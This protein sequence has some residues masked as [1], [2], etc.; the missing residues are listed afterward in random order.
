MVELTADEVRKWLKNR[1][2][3][4][5]L[6]TL[7]E[8]ETGYV[9]KAADAFREKRGKSFKREMSKKKKT[10]WRGE[11]KIDQRSKSIKFDD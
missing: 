3:T 6:Q 7:F 4:R 1:N 8:E 2:Y 5:T 10:S 9:V 11:G